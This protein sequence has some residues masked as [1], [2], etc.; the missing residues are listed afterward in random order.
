MNLTKTQWP[1]GWIP[2]ADPMNGPVECLIRMDNLQQDEIGAISLVRGLKRVSAANTLIDYPNDIYSKIINGQELLW[3]GLNSAGREVVRTKVGDFSDAVTVCSGNARATF[4]DAL[5]EVLICN[6]TQ[7]KK[8]NG[9]TIQDLGLQTPGTPQVSAV[10]Q[11]TVAFYNGTGTGTSQFVTSRIAGTWGLLQG[12]GSSPIGGQDGINVLLDLVTSVGQV[13]LT[14]LPNFKVDSTAIGDG[15]AIDPGTDTW[16]FTVTPDDSSVVTSVRLDVIVDGHTENSA[17]YYT[18]TFD[19]S[20]LLPGLSTDS[21][22]TVKRSDFTRVGTSPTND[23][24]TVT[25]MVVTINATAAIS[26]DVKYFAVIGGIAGQLNGN[27]VWFQLNKNNNGNYVA[28][29]PAGP[30]TQAYTVINGFVTLTPAPVEPQVTDIEFYRLTAGSSPESFLGAPYLVAST[31]PGVP[32]KDITSD[33][34]AIETN[35]VLN[36]FLLSLQ[37]LSDGNGVTDTIY[38]IIGLFKERTIYMG[39]SFIYLSDNLNPDAVDTRY[40]LKAF[41]DPTETNLWIKP[42]TNNVL[43]LAT[44]KDLYEITGTFTPQPDGTIDVT[45]IPIGENYPPLSYDA[46]YVEGAIFYTASDGIRATSGSNSQLISPQL[47]LLFQGENRTGIPSVVVT[48]NNTAKYG[49]AV[50]KTRLY[51]SLPNM[52]GDRYLFV[53]DLINKRWRLQFTDPLSLFVTPSD[54]VLLGYNIS[55][56][57]S[58]PGA[59]FELDN[60]IGVTDNTGAQIEGLPMTFQTVFDHNGQPRNR[61]DTFTLKLVCDTGGRDVVVSIAKDNGNFV[62]LAADNS[63]TGRING[64]GTFFFNLSNVTLGFR[65][66][67]KIQDYQLLTSFKLYEVTIEYDP[68]PEQ[69]DFLRIQPSNLG[70]ASRKR[71]VNYAFVIDT[72]GNNITF[73][74]FVDNTNTGVAPSVLNFST[75]LKQTVIFY[76]TQETIGTDINGTLSGGVFEFYGLNLEEIISEKLPVPCEYLII[77]NNDYGTPDRKRHS[78]YKFQI[79]TRGGDVQFTPKLDGVLGTPVTYNTSE[80]RVVEYFFNSDTIAIEVGGVLKSLAG[81][82]FEFYGVVTPENVEKLPP[83][84]EYYRI[85]NTNYGVAG[86]KRIRTMPMVLDTYGKRVQF[87]AILDNLPL[88]TSIFQTT[89]KTTVLHYFARDVFN[90]DYGGQLTSLENPPVP[91][92]FYELLN[93]ENVETLPTPKLYDQLGP[94]RFDKIGKIFELRLRVIPLLGLTTIP[95]FISGDKD[96]EIPEYGSQTIGGTL[97]VN[98]GLDDIYTIQLPKS[99]NLAIMRVVLGPTIEPFCRYDM[100]VRVSTSGMESDSKWIPVR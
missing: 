50:G 15:P 49:I 9:T 90:V 4:G 18:F 56:D 19:N 39:L 20:A 73:T 30:Q 67:V 25:A 70:T 29:S 44:T 54:R 89:G 8:D 59:L 58:F 3:A 99:I 92:E 66:A 84:L 17:N 61:K 78:S 46:A 21:V 26:C 65:Y 57:S 10:S 80:K 13:A 94:V 91:F 32:V 38:G 71:I 60:G 96:V 82:P 69:L 72:L 33:N 88:D 6:G 55:A 74:P 40:T 16:Q 2:S 34:D 43:I 23:W 36:Q 97:S 81:R 47:N 42:V 27:Y 31:K 24:T 7:R 11:P 85:P 14:D 45:I 63:V 64:N 53:Y 93:P 22:L 98:P 12:H 62:Q 5:G 52:N 87:Q 37:P 100:Q 86:N 1:L 68:R 95:W 48:P 76:F 28:K 83:R 41:G 75:P 77:P 79:N 51:A 35:I